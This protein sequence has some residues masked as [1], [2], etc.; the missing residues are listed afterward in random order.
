VTTIRTVAAHEVVQT[1]FPRPVTEADELAMA[2]GRAIDAA[3]SRFSHEAGQH[4]H[5]SAHRMREFASTVLTEELRDI[6]LEVSEGQRE[7][8][9]TEVDGVLRAFRR[10]EVYGLPRPKSRL[11][12]IDGVAGVYA[13]PDYWNERDRFY[14]MKSYNAVPPPPD[15]ALQLQLFQLAFSG[16][17]AFLFCIDRHAVPVAAT[18]TPLA[19]LTP[20]ETRTTLDLAYRVALEKGIEKVVEYVDNPR[21]HYQRPAPS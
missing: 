15:V 5:P 19:P 1:A 13:Q 8:I 20:E 11:I 2:V 4:R 12:V 3:L 17:S 16:L 10:S 21:V 18:V 14:E 9:L 7:Q 6:D